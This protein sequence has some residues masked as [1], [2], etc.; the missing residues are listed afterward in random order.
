MAN[1]AAI[2]P[3]AKADLE[4][5][6]VE[7]YIPG[8]NEIL[9][10][11]EVISFN[12]IESKIARLALLPVPYPTILG[13]SFGGTVEA[14]GSNIKNFKVGDKVAV[15]K[16]YTQTGIQ[17]GAYQRYVLAADD[18]ASKT[19]NGVDLTDAAVLIGNLTTVVGLFGVRLSLN[20]PELKSAPTPQNTKILI[21]GG[22]SS[23]GSLAV[24]WVTQAGYDAVT[25]SSPNHQ[26]FVSRLGA[27]YV[28]D[29]TQ[30]PRAL[31]QDLTNHGPYGYVVDTIGLPATV[32]LNAQVV[33]AQGGGKVYATL[34]SFG[35]EAL[36]G[37]VIR[38]FASWP[39]IFDEDKTNLE[40]WTY[41]TWFPEALAKARLV[42]HPVEKVKG[43]L[44]G[45][46][47]AAL[48]R[49]LAGVSGVKLVA[50]PWE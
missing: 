43:G 23:V 6:E 30:E 50:D 49:L 21:Y 25:T 7:R 46:V 28:A 39:D 44:K 26:D 38:E 9:V 16:R 12:P 33:A 22:T 4:I 18:T 31:V 40:K 24:Q 1:L 2:I 45:G 14:I 27:L 5:R 19:P 34:P 42:V 10:K 36:P 29:H 17:Y 47:N 35:P 37:G 8:P 13:L 3:S 48:D 20:R 41:E 32:A 15:R 11:N